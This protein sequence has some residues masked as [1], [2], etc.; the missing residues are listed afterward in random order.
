MKASYHEFYQV[1]PFVMALTQTGIFRQGQLLS[2]GESDTY[3][4]ILEEKKGKWTS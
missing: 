2:R 1:Q 4:R 3:F